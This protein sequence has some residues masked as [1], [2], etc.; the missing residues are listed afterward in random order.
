MVCFVLF[1]AIFQGA[2]EG[3]ADVEMGLKAC[4]LV[5]VFGD[6]IY[7][8]HNKKLVMENPLFVLGDKHQLLSLVENK[9]VQKKIF[10]LAFLVPLLIGGGMFTKK[11]Y[12]ILRGY[13]R[14]EREKLIDAMRQRMC[15]LAESKGMGDSVKCS[16]CYNNL[17]NV[18]LKPCLHM[19][20]CHE[21][22]MQ[23]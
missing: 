14:R 15:D 6:V 23:L 11:L 1:F 19:S 17:K 13:L 10:I 21:C 5:T 16:V 9:L 18:I 22:L 3:F 4:A 20:L 7:D 12:E 8:V 2:Y